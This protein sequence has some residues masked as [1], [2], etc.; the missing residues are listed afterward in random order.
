MLQAIASYASSNAAASVFPSARSRVGLKVWSQEDDM[1]VRL[2]YPDYGALQR[3]FADRT[4]AAIKHRAAKLRV[5]SKRH[6]WTQLEVARLRRLFSQRRPTDT[7]LEAAFPHIPLR[8]ILNK[9]RHVGMVRE[10]IAPKILGVPVLDAVRQRA[11]DE[12]LTMV[13]L[14]ELA[15]TRH[16]FQHS[17]RSIVWRHVAAAVNFLGGALMPWW[18]QEDETKSTMTLAA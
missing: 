2:L 13:E 14:D 8:K 5:V 4:L 15:S 7:D 11:H 17:S 1:V 9:A 3:H 6:V 10:R 12:G 16:Y 18:D